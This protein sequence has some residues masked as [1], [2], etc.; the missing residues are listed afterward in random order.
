MATKIKRKVGHR[1]LDEELR[2]AQRIAAHAAFIVA[3]PPAARKHAESYL[4]T[5]VCNP[6]R[7][8]VYS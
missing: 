4:R 5:I 7:A 8:R 2:S 1:S 6:H 3:P